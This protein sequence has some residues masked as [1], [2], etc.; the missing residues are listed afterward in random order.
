M[1]QPIYK[2]NKR[3]Q[4]PMLDI[5]FSRPCQVY[6][7]L[8][9][10]KVKAAGPSTGSVDNLTVEQQHANRAEVDIAEVDKNI[11]IATKRLEVLKAVPG[12]GKRERVKAEEKK[13]TT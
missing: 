9:S 8:S 5:F 10:V 4:D 1:F 12:K 2:Y 11:E 3:L 7:W 6:T 13:T